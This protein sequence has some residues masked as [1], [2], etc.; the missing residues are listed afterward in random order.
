[1]AVI[2]AHVLWTASLLSQP[3]RATTE[4]VLSTLMRDTDRAKNLVLTPS[5]LIGMSTIIPGAWIRWQCYRALKS[6]FTAEL[7]IQKNH[8]LITTGPYRFVRHPSYSGILMALPGMVC[9]FGG[10]GSWLRESGVLDTVAGS[11]FFYAFALFLGT[12]ISVG[13]SRMG[14]EDKELKGFFGE[15]WD[16]WAS[17]VQY[18]LMP[19]VY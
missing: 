12:T 5:S 14:R 16:K 19:G 4:I 1:M 11:A 10:R 9:W 2:I 8:K 13:V 18:R 15:E 3:A 17:R 6:Q 7:S